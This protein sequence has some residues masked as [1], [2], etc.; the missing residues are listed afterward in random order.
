MPYVF[1]SLAPFALILAPILALSACST[2]TSLIPN[3]F[4]KEDR[5]PV[6]DSA[7]DVTAAPLE[8]DVTTPPGGGGTTAEALDTASAEEVA[9]ATNVSAPATGL[10]G[11]TIAALGDPTKPGFWLMTPLVDSEGPGRVER[12]GG[13]V[14]QV[15]LIP[16]EGEAGAGS[17]ISLSAMRALGLD[18]TDLVPLKVYEG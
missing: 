7:A 10:L 12:E 14:V 3:P 2:A 11:E 15:T 13:A 17:Q 6:P 18:L 5:T 8:A 1:R 4:P 9:E 16:L